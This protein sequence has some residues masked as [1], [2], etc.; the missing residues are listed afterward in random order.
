ML[1]AVCVCRPA[2]V[3]FA[4]A[5]VFLALTAAIVRTPIMLCCRADVMVCLVCMQSF[6]L[7]VHQLEEAEARAT[8]FIELHL[9]VVSSYH[10]VIVVLLMA[11]RRLAWRDLQAVNKRFYLA[12]AIVC[13]S[14]L[15]ALVSSSTL[16]WMTQHPSCA[17][18]RCCVSIEFIIDGVSCSASVCGALTCWAPRCCSNTG[19]HMVSNV[20]QVIFILMF[21][22]MS[23]LNAG[24]NPHAKAAADAALSFAILGMLA[25]NR[26]YHCRCCVLI[27]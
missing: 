13:V 6:V 16:C 15:F 24:L 18:S 26:H 17:G 22:A 21:M 4:F 2:L 11:G 27:G 7:R 25:S 14:F 9:C 8:D 19:W 12:I 10:L 23:M 1:C 5:G 3:L 20:H